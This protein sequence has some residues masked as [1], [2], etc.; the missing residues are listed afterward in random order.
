LLS[1]DLFSEI[2]IINWQ[3]AVNVGRKGCTM[4]L[5]GS[6][7]WLARLKKYAVISKAHLFTNTSQDVAIE[8]PCLNIQNDQREEREGMGGNTGVGESQGKR[9]TWGERTYHSSNMYFI[10]S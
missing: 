7:H 2:L 8:S 1:D 4:L 3:A 9:S 10:I 6:H 5:P